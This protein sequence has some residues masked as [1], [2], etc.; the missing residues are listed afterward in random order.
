MEQEIQFAHTYTYPR[1][2]ECPDFPC[3]WNDMFDKLVKK[4]R[5]VQRDFKALK[6]WKRWVIAFLSIAPVMI[7]ERQFSGSLSENLAIVAPTLLMIVLFVGLQMLNHF[8][9]RKWNKAKKNTKVESEEMRCSRCG[10]KVSPTSQYCG[11]C[12]NKLS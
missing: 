3:S 9:T 2:I 6:A 1:R 5:E 7:Y 8:L 11:S 10:N 12:G 4:W